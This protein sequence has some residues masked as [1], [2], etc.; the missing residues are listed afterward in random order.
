MVAP[1]FFKDFWIFVHIFCSWESSNVWN[2]KLFTISS[3]IYFLCNLVCTFLLFLCMEIHVNSRCLL[4]FSILD[5]FHVGR[6]QVLF[7][8]W[9]KMNMNTESLYFRVFQIYWIEDEI[10]FIIFYFRNFDLSVHSK[11]LVHTESI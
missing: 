1:V 7:Q 10:F 8:Y 2:V 5:S 9:M 3:I 6:V 4:S 11:V